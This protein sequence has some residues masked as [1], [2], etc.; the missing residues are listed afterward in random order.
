V[1]PDVH[2]NN[3]PLVA[4]PYTNTGC[5]SIKSVQRD[6]R[7]SF[8]HRLATVQSACVALVV[9]CTLSVIF[10]GV[11]VAA[12]PAREFIGRGGDPRVFIWSLAW[13]PHALSHHLNPFIVKS[14]WPP[15]GYNLTWA[16]TVPGPSIIA[17]PVTRRYG[18]IVSFNLL[19]LLSPMFAA[20]IAFVLCRHLSRRFWPALT[21]GY[22][23]G[24]STYMIGQMRGHLHMVMIFPVPLGVYLVLLHFEDRI[25]SSL[26]IPA[27]TLLLVF[28][29]LTS[30]EVVATAT[31]IGGIILTVEYLVMPEEA[32]HRVLGSITLISV[33]YLFAAVLLSPF[34]YYLLL[35][36]D[37]RIFNSP[38][39]Y[40]ADVLNFVLPTPLTLVGGHLFLPLTTRFMGNLAENGAYLG[41]GL[42]AAIVFFARSG[43]DGRAR[44]VLIVGML[45]VAV[46]A[47]GPNLHILGSTA[48]P[49]PWT[50]FEKLP[51]I[52]QALPG[53]VVM[54]L[55]LI[56]AV[57]LTYYLSETEVPLWRRV[58]V[59]VAS[60]VFILPRFP[61]VT[62]AADIPRFFTPG[63]F[64]RY[65]SPNEIVLTLPAGV[66]DDGLLWQV[67][68]DMYFRLL[69]PRVGSIPQAFTGWSIIGDLYAQHVGRHF[70]EDLTRFLNVNSVR[71]IV[72]DE[73]KDQPWRQIFA[74]AGWSATEVGGVLIYRVPSVKPLDSQSASEPIH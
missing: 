64:E 2:C 53:R 61:C 14:I 73:K 49:L 63:T 3:E 44:K 9:Y 34:L 54:F 4:L 1:W 20:F 69:C 13:W 8:R 41:P 24:F 40:S 30:M 67:S 26:F 62:T 70:V 45:L 50:L 27:F 32:K 65:L 36:R 59:G 60:V 33:S 71:V 16:T 21:G 66:R 5:P 57:M 72:L 39:T 25:R 51:L 74:V 11:D 55:F 35:Q 23:F 29:F 10:F 19:T 31:L 22:I 68:A 28:E 6:S 48:I 42:I 46:I 52:E 47:L 38:A 56:G 18:P 58:I 17:Y 15:G 12:H 37:F 7:L 43:A